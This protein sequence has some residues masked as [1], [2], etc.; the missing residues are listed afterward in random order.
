MAFK[1]N[2][3]NILKQLK[4]RQTELEKEL[5]EKKNDDLSNF[6]MLIDSA[7][8]VDWHD[9]EKVQS[10]ASE[11]STSKLEDEPIKKLKASKKAKYTRLSA[12]KMDFLKDM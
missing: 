1:A 7:R 12:R 9:E 2:K 8:I 3:L 10:Q 11:L 4:A 5:A 6:E